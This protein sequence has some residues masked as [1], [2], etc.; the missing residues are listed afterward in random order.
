MVCAAET[1]DCRTDAWLARA[2]RKALKQPWP[3]KHAIA[4]LHHFDELELIHKLKPVKV[5]CLVLQLPNV[6]LFLVIRRS[7]GHQDQV[8]GVSMCISF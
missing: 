1:L 3:H 6:R 4:G 7:P 8:A 2:L 5:Q